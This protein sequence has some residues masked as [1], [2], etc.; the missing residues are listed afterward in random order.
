[1]EKAEGKLD[2][3]E[4]TFWNAL[5]EKYLK[6]LEANSV[7]EKKIEEDLIQLRLYETV[8]VTCEESYLCMPKLFM[9]VG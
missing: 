1:M 2:K 4:H 7:Q 6:P 9:H 3:D 5:I 8:T